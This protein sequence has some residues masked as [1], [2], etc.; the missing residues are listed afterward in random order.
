M[1]IFIRTPEV[2]L[3]TFSADDRIRRNA[4]VTVTGTN[5]GS[6]VSLP[7]KT[8]TN[9]SED[10]DTIYKT[11][12]RPLP[13]LQG[14]EVTLEGT[15]GALKRAEGKF[16]CYSTDQF[17]QFEAALLRP[18]SDVTIKYGYV[19][20]EASS[21]GEFTGKV[22][23][24]DFKYTAENYIECTFKAVGQGSVISKT[25]VTGIPQTVLNGKSFVKNY[26]DFNEVVPVRTV[27]DYF[28]WEIQSLTNTL[29]TNQFRPDEGGYGTNKDYYVVRAPINYQ[30]TETTNDSGR[31]ANQRLVYVR[32]G[33][34]IKKL[35][36][37]SELSR[38]DYIYFDPTLA[39]SNLRLDGY[40]LV[41][42]D[43]L[44]ALWGV[45]LGFTYIGSDGLAGSSGGVGVQGSLGQRATSFITSGNTDTA[46]LHIIAN[47][48]KLLQDGVDNIYINRDELR[49]LEKKY[50]QQEPI[51]NADAT[52]KKLNASINMEEFL[53]GI[54]EVIKK[55][56]AGLIELALINNPNPG[57][58]IGNQ[59]LPRN[60]M[61]I[62]DKNAKPKTK[63]E[64]VVFDPANGDGVTRQLLLSGK[65]P[66]S[67]AAEAFTKATNTA[68][69][70]ASAGTGEITG[71]AR[72]TNGSTTT[73]STPAPATGQANPNFN[74][75]GQAASNSVFDD[76]LNS[77]VASGCSSEGVSALIEFFRERI[78]AEVDK[79]AVTTIAAPQYP[80]ELDLTL[81]G[82]EGFKFGDLVTSKLLPNV[83]RNETNESKIGFTITRI[84]HKIENNDWT[85]SLTGTCRLLP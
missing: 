28:D 7:I 57:G 24:F 60:A 11:G 42:C 19:N 70:L 44:R 68:D 16:V 81:N 64:P 30:P 27:F 75:A 26:K 18:G 71:Y 50:L 13:A 36:K 49:A 29:T 73:T 39:Y 21:A 83:Y 69:P 32:F 37:F 17:D 40:E 43:P 14:V 55:S 48:L 65:V 31:Y 56:T 47:E 22:Y 34:I 59:L 62:V 53:Q 72:S 79:G 46:P 85:T 61:I 58:L 10:D 6:T 3:S 9:F 82:I 51:T 8:D 25:S 4:Y 2:D 1:S 12:R 84:S 63:P 54:F 52:D 78:Q 20:S 80:L 41:S 23:S 35:N 38:G 77:M 15:A 45:P 67:V 74:F 76:A 5:N 66:K 33:Y